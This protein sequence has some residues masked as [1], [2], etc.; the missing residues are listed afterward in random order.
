[1]RTPWL[2]RLLTRADTEAN[3]PNMPPKM[4]IWS[5]FPSVWLVRAIVIRTIPI[6]EKC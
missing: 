4:T 6:K 3:T 2:A 5:R 1:M